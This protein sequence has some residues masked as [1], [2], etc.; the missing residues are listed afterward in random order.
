MPLD[1]A[2][3]QSV[4]EEVAGFADA[5]S[6]VAADYTGLSAASMT[7]L[8]KQARSEGVTVKIVRNTLAKRGFVGTKYECLNEALQGPVV[9]FFAT[10]EPSAAARLAHN[11]AKEHEQLVVKALSLGDGL[12]PSSQL[13]AVAELPTRIE[14]IAQLLAVMQAPITK[15]VRTIAAPKL[16]LVRTLVAVRDSK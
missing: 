4:V 6:V 5:I 11:F 2:Q 7:E 16:K 15:L 8:R 12:I 9:L 14:A 1:L 13:K 3:K 10:V